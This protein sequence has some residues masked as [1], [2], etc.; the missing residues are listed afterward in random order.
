MTLQALPTPAQLLRGQAALP[1][2]DARQQMVLLNFAEPGIPRMFCG[3]FIRIHLTPAMLV[4]G[5]EE[6]WQPAIYQPQHALKDKCCRCNGPT[7]VVGQWLRE[8][9][10]PGCLRFG[11]SESHKPKQGVISVQVP[12]DRVHVVDGRELVRTV[13]LVLDRRYRE[14]ILAAVYRTAGMLCD[15][16]GWKLL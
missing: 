16:Y 8:C 1:N 9:I 7:K 5:E 2:A 14:V 13:V 4:G 12:S 11:M 3:E 15:Q 10:T 6:F